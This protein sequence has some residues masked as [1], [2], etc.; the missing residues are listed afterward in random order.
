[1]KEPRPLRLSDL[2]EQK[3][4]GMELVV[5]GIGDPE[6]TGAHT[7]EIHEPAR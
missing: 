1:M 7:S 4:F 5:P 2:L 6:V 3:V